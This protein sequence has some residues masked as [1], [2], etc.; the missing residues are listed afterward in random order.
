MYDPLSVSPCSYLV[1]Y[2]ITW[3]SHTLDT[4]K[5]MNTKKVVK[6]FFFFFF[7]QGSPFTDRHFACLYQYHRCVIAGWPWTPHWPVRRYA[8]CSLTTLWRIT[9][10]ST[11]IRHQLY[12]TMTPHCC[13]RMLGWIR[14]ILSF[15]PLF[16][17]LLSSLF[18]SLSLSL[19][20]SC[21]HLLALSPALWKLVKGW[22]QGHLSHA[23]HVHTDLCRHTYMY[24]AT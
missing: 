17:S 9:D 24:R 7:K 2:H 5:L 19:P 12:H 18:L 3:Y 11:S 8:R 10:M 21:S 20:L 16:L 14:L 1:V 13:S 6:I 15:L 23:P 4:H 22:G